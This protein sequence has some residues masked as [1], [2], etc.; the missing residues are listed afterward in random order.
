VRLG[1]P[2]L[3]ESRIEGHEGGDELDPVEGV[4]E[5]DEPG[6]SI[7]VEMEATTTGF[8]EAIGKGDSATFCWEG[9]SCEQV[10]EV[11]LACSTECSADGGIYE[12]GELGSRGHARVFE[13]S[14]AGAI[15]E[16]EKADVYSGT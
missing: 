4:A 3:D 1:Q 16:L 8:G 5:R 10:L 11:E 6:R 14:K 13:E 12:I 9:F 7:G 2:E 15:G